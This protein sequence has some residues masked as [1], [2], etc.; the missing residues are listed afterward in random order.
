MFA[1]RCVTTH[2]E[3]VPD[4]MTVGPDPHAP[5]RCRRRAR[6]QPVLVGTLVVDI[7]DARTNATVWRSLASSDIGPTDKPESRDKKIAKATEKMF[8]NSPPKS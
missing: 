6:V 5:I 1:A 2:R 3:T 7:S 8:K 4:G